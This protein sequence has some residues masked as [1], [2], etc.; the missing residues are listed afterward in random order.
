[1]FGICSCSSSSSSSRNIYMGSSI[2]RN[3][4]IPKLVS[5]GI[6][7]FRG[8]LSRYLRARKNPK[9]NNIGRPARKQE[10][11]KKK[12]TKQQQCEMK[13]SECTSRDHLFVSFVDSATSKLKHYTTN[14]S[15]ETCEHGF[16]IAIFMSYTRISWVV[17]FFFI[18]AKAIL[19]S[20]L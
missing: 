15:C 6:S 17:L 19:Y 4:A 7:F 2:V 1:M 3:H 8:T 9:K 5:V 16:F 20:H 13:N 14:K 11:K 18:V 10:A 12:Q